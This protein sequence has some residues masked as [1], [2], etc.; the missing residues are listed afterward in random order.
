MKVAVALILA[1]MFLSAYA[2]PHSDVN[3]KNI[4]KRLSYVPSPLTVTVRSNWYKEIIVG[5]IIV[6]STA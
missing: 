5:L 1:A 6:I 2:F 3:N 4:E